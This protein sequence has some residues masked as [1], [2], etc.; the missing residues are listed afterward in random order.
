MGEEVVVAPS[1][2]VSTCSALASPLW[3]SSTKH[4]SFKAKFAWRSKARNLVR[5]RQVKP[6]G[7]N[8]QRRE[9]VS[10]QS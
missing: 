3:T 10:S 4:F 2:V 7:T 8:R 5:V 9:D 1:G 6:E